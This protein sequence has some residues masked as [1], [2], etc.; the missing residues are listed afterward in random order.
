LKIIIPVIYLFS[1]LFL[2]PI[3]TSA[4]IDNQSWTSLS[5]RK[6]VSSNTI[7]QIKPTERRFNNLKDHQNSSID[8]SFQTKIKNGWSFGG[9][10]RT[11]FV[12]NE[13]IRQFLWANITHS[14]NSDRIKMSNKVRL[15]YA[16]DINDRKDP[17]FLRW[18]FQIGPNLKKKVEP[19]IAIVSFFRMNGINDFQRI[20]YEPGLK[21]KINK[22][23]IL[24]TVFRRET[25]LNR[26]PKIKTNVYV[27][28]LGYYIP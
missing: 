15:H 2:F 13:K 28:T 17:D 7:I 25:T 10:A 20:R 3:Y 9:L 23:W 16:L 4:Q 27:V 21:W 19:F 12:P 8:L 14:F 11:W 6:Q 22:N 26:K 18:N 1:I 5:I 24:S